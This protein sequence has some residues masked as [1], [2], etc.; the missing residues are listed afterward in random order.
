MTRK[1]RGRGKKASVQSKKLQSPS[2]QNSSPTSQISHEESEEE[3]VEQ[4]NNTNTSELQN[5][6]ALVQDHEGEQAENNTSVIRAESPIHVAPGEA[7]TSFGSL[8]QE[9]D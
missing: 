6:P 9:A 4:L 2:S 7:T 3:Q 5:S 8:E 1:G